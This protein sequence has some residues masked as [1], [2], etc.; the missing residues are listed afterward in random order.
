MRSI[1][2]L[3]GVTGD[4]IKGAVFSDDNDLR[5]GM[6]E[7]GESVTLLWP[8]NDSLSRFADR[9]ANM[10]EE[11]VGEAGTDAARDEVA[12]REI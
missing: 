6:G 10:A 5:L 9:L 1:R 11:I 12:G 8:T 7:I 4:D 3:P 2:K